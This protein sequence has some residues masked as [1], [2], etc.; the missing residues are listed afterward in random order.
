MR[1][2]AYVY[3]SPI[4]SRCQ[5]ANM[6]ESILFDHPMMGQA[7]EGKPPPAFRTALAECACVD[8]AADLWRP[9]LDPAQHQVLHGVEADR[10][11]PE[12][13]P[14]TPS[15]APSPPPRPRPRPPWRPPCTVE[16][17]QQVG[18]HRHGAENTAPALLQ[19]PNTTTRPDRPTCRA[20]RLLTSAAPHGLRVRNSRSMQRAVAGLR[21]I[22]PLGFAYSG[23]TSPEPPNSAG[24]S[25][26]FGSPLCIGSTVSA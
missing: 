4:T 20:V 3:T 14:P 24:K 23:T 16:G 2:L 25:R 15:A 17:V 22:G 13:L 8:E 18:R 6:Y 12:R 5:V 1:S 21:L 19:A 7:V 11:E 9:A 10:P 26:S